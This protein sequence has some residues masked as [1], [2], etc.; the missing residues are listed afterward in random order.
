MICSG[1]EVILIRHLSLSVLSSLLIGSLA[2]LVLRHPR[3]SSS[4]A[5]LNYLR[6]QPAEV[7]P[8]AGRSRAGFLD[9]GAPNP[10]H[11]GHVKAFDTAAK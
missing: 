11:I 2:H 3:P 1:K 9:T 10:I 8:A 7:Q 6:E 4:P 5:R